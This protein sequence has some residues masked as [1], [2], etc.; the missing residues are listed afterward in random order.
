M[1][2]GSLTPVVQRFIDSYGLVALF[3]LFVLEGSMLLYIV[4]SESLVPGAILLLAESAID[5]PL[6]IGVA[7][8]GSTVGQ[9]LLFVLSKRKGRTYLLSRSWFK[10]SGERVEQFEDWFANWG[11]VTVPLSNMLPL[12]RGML[13]VPAGFADMDTRKFIVLSTVGTLLI[14]TILTAITVSALSS[15]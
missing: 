1:D 3:V 2:I 5:Y 7:V 11:P 13:T 10:V 8:I 4:P 9:T 15:L 6:I 14:E 12:V